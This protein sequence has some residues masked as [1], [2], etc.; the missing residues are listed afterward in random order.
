MTELD[1]AATDFFKAILETGSTVL[2]HTDFKIKIE[3]ELGHRPGDRDRA[4]LVQAAIQ[5]AL[6]ITNAS[7]RPV[8]IERTTLQ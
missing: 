6:D 1:Q 7:A 8:E 5:H 4:R 2:G 3:V